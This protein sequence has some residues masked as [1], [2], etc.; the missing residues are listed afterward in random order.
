MGGPL[1]IEL[2]PVRAGL[3]ADP[4]DYSWSSYRAHALGQ[5]VGLWRPHPEYLALG[6]TPAARRSAYRQLFEQELS[7]GVLDDI[8]FALNK[9]LVLGNERFRA[10]VEEFMESEEL[11]GSN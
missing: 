9:G 11:K 3:A 5:A 10:E 4:A 2:N 6:D 1:Q 8:R 7:A